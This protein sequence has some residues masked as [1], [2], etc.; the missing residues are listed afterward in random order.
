LAFTINDFSVHDG[1]EYAKGGEGGNG[2]SQATRYVSRR[3]RD[4]SREDREPRTLFSEKEDSLSFYKANRLLGDGI[5]PKT[6]DILHL[7]ISFEKEDDFNQLGIDEEPRQQAVREMTR[8]AMKKMAEDLGTSQLRWTAGIHRNTDNPHVH[9][10][11]H[12]DYLNR[13]T[14][15]VRRLQTLP[16]QMRVGWERSDNGKQI[17]NPGSI[18]H[19]LETLL[20]E[21]IEKSKQSKKSRSQ[22]GEI[23]LVNER[24]DRLMLGRVMVIEDQIERLQKMREDAIKFRESRRYEFTDGRGGSRLLS[25]HDLRQRASLKADLSMTN[26]NSTPSPEKQKQMRD[27][28]I[29]YELGRNEELISKLRSARTAELNGISYMLGRLNESSQPIIEKAEGIKSWFKMEQRPLPLPILSRAELSELQNRAIE[30]GDVLRIRNLE[31]IRTSL[32]KE[33]GSPTRLDKEIGRLKAQLFVAQSN[34]AMEQDSARRF[35]ETKHI[36]RWAIDPDNPNDNNRARAEQRSLAEIEQMLIWETDQARFIGANQVHWDDAR[37]SGAKARVEELIS[38]RESL[39]DRIEAKRA[40]I[41]A[42]VSQKKEVV[43]TLEGILA[44]EEE[45]YRDEVKD[46]PAPLFTEQDLKQ[47]DSQAGHRSDPEFLHTLVELEHSHDARTDPKGISSIPQRFGRAWA[48]EIMA[49]IRLRESELSL[50]KFNDRREHINMIV[51]DDGGRKITIKRLVDI[52]QHS[53]LDQLFRPFAQR[54]DR[55]VEVAAAVEAYEERLINDH[56]N[57]S[58]SHSL[59]QSVTREYRQK[60]SEVYPQRPFP[61]PHFTPWEIG[62]LE[63]HA[64]KELDPY[65][66]E[67]Y[68]NLYLAALQDDRGDH[69]QKINI[70]KAEVN[71]LDPVSFHHRPSRNVEA[72]IST[73]QTRHNQ[74]YEMSLER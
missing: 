52:E 59:L 8:S 43:S 3:E 17:I 41:S 58:G 20:N 14:G 67:K 29:A 57:I 35:E 50:M 16:K 44:R 72:T 48:R 27:E 11:I 7:V 22:S 25:E 28:V 69:S 56:K 12:R 18:S 32:A 4:E 15:R 55:H 45:R 24:E 64:A 65:L 34:L 74:T 47:L 21:H 1:S 36:R 51:N 10:L 49:E 33:N 30:T 54:N 23:N 73:A 39:L 42:G 71:L 13:E 6:D 40:E 5:D 26:I 70:G 9:L 46:S 61:R 31:E 37:R 2:T 53:P 68:E 19:S 62:K 60:F 66:R 63:L 38:Q